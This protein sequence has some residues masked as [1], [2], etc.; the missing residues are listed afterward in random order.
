MKKTNKEEKKEAT[1]VSND[2]NNN[3]LSTENSQ[4]KKCP[5]CKT[6]LKGGVFS[7]NVLLDK[8]SVEL[9]NFMSSNNSEYYC[10]HCGQAILIE[11]RTLRDNKIEEL[12]QKMNE[13]IDNVP[14]VTIHNPLNWDYEIIDMVTAQITTGTGV[15]FEILT[16]IDDLF[17]QKSE[18]YNSITKES[19]MFC[20]RILR[21]NALKLGANAILGTDIDYT[22][23]GGIKALFMICMAGT[24]VKLKNPE[25]LGEKARTNFFDFENILKEL[26][27]LNNLS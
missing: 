7:G 8:K 15:F 5:N 20:K 22:E 26:E 12:S 13:I 24:A 2:I 18:K 23:V 1:E 25:I 10:T 21:V 27:I 6:K 14:V 11:A 9:I 3:E 16:T 4:I 19:E 17:G